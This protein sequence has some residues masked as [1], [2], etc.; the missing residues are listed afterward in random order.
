MVFL[1]GQQ[2]YFFP[3]IQIIWELHFQ[4][5]RLVFQN[6]CEKKGGDFFFEKEAILNNTIYIFGC[7]L[8]EDSEAGKL[9]FEEL[10]VQ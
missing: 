10:P 5:Y 9:G 7:A 1:F 4:L 2:K 8:L 6:W 3:P